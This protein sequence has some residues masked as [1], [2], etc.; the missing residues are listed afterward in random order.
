MTKRAGAATARTAA[1][2]DEVLGAL[3]DPTRRALFERL[4]REGPDTATRLAGDL[5][6]SR[7]AVVKHLQVLAAA[8]LVTT[9]RRGREVR[10]E[11]DAAA[12]GPANA[13]FTAT[14]VAW[15]RR[16]GRLRERVRRT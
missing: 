16:L 8:D 13:W 4:V 1:S 15:D 5:P 7:Q 14:G 3:A 2:L 10:Y 6:I 12:L 11:A 9:E